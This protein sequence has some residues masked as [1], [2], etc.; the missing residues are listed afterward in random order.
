M[1]TPYLHSPRLCLRPLSVLDSEIIYQHWTSDPEV[2]KFMRWEPHTSVEET[3]AWLQEEET[4]LQG[5]NFTWGFE[6]DITGQLIGS[7][8]LQ[9]NNRMDCY[10]L[11]FNLMKRYWNQGYTTEACNKMLYFAQKQK[12]YHFY[13]CHDQENLASQRVLEKLG[14]QFTTTGVLIDFSGYR[15]YYTREYSLD[16]PPLP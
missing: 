6:L 1:I 14:F 2:A 9:W 15:R 10:E 11:G 5:R 13:A 16:L 8:C 4:Q 12:Q 3:I 7:G